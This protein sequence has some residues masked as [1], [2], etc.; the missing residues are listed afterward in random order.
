MPTRDLN[1]GVIFTG[2]IEASLQSAIDKLKGGMNELNKSFKES[3][4]VA[5]DTKSGFLSLNWVIKDII[6][7]M[8]KLLMVQA[9]WYGA[10]AVLFAAIEAPIKGIKS[11]IE[12]TNEIEKGRAEMLRWGATSGEVTEDMKRQV[13]LIVVMMRRATTE[14]PVTLQ[15]LSKAVQAFAGAGVEYPVLAGMVEGIAKLKTSFKEI[16]I[17]QWAVA[18]R[19]AFNVF[20]TAMKEGGTE[21]E[22]MLLIF[23]KILRAQAVGIARPEEFTKVLKFMGSITDLL[24]GNIDQML[25]MAVAISNVQGNIS[26]AARMARS[27]LLSMQTDKFLNFAKIVGIPIDKSKNLFSQLDVIIPELAKKIDA[28]NP[29]V[30]GWVNAL[31]KTMGKQE[32]DT[33]LK[34]IQQYKEYVRLTK[35][36]AESKGGLTAAAAVMAMPPSEQWK[37]FVNILK[38]VSRAITEYLGSDLR[39]ITGTFVDF[40]RGIL[41]A[42]DP[43]GI[44]ADKIDKLGPAGKFAYNI[45]TSIVNAFKNL[46]VI[47]QPV[48]ILFEAFG[49]IILKVIQFLVE[50]NK[51]LEFLITMLLTKGILS[52]GKWVIGLA[53]VVTAFEGIISIIGQTLGSFSG[54]GLSIAMIIA[55]IIG[56]LN[57]LLIVLTT[58]GMLISALSEKDT[59]PELMKF[60]LGLYTKSKE[61]LEKELKSLQES[62]KSFQQAQI[63]S[64]EYV[65]REAEKT[66]GLPVGG[67]LLI[68]KEIR[69]K[70]AETIIPYTAE[71]KFIKEKIKLTK[72]YYDLINKQVKE[73]K[74]GGKEEPPIM[75]K[76][77]V[78]TQMAARR[79]IFNA[80]IAERKSNLATESHLLE[81]QFK[82]NLIS[83]E[84]YYRRRQVLRDNDAKLF[85][86]EVDYEEQAIKDTYAQ[87]LGINIKGM[88]FETFKNK[89]NKM[90]E[91]LITPNKFGVTALSVQGDKDTETRKSNILRAREEIAK[92]SF[93]ITENTN[94]RIQMSDDDYFRWRALQDTRELENT[95]HVFAM[96]NELT[97]Q[98][99]DM[100]LWAIEEERKTNKFRYDNLYISTKE[101]YDKELELINQEEASKKAALA[102]DL[103]A[104]KADNAAK[105][106]LAGE[107]GNLIGKLRDQAALYERQNEEKITD[108]TRQALSKRLDLQKQ[109]LTDWEILYDEGIVP[110]VSE[111]IRRIIGEY[112][113][114]GSRIKSI[115]DDIAKGMATSFEDFFFDVFKIQLKSGADYFN[116]F[117]DVLLRAMSKFLGEQIVKSFLELLALYL[118]KTSSGG[119]ETWPSGASVYMEHSGGLISEA[120]QYR[121]LNNIPRFHSGIGPDE[122]LSILK[123]NEGVFTPGQMRA[124]GDRNLS[125][126]VNVENKTSSPANAKVG[127][128]KFDGKKY[129]VSVILEDIDKGGVLRHA[130]AGVR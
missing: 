75:G 121:W 128:T 5:D 42:V 115:V 52:L 47:L 102:R 31:S 26:S 77:Q 61:D 20:G 46:G 34:F 119:G 94:K 113:K 99:L 83:E 108:I 66:H 86:E 7:D 71:I 4:K 73:G 3:K 53:G 24:G 14:F 82:A 118:S 127:E 63:E 79:A 72:E 62:L 35:E 111:A 22:K 95:E 56:R 125:V 85:K 93:K 11:M 123:K 41:V 45:T 29:V 117:I 105:I 116:A 2:K 74:G 57:P 120:N 16:N 81:G 39:K 67:L 8:E 69:E 23:E 130:I 124:L 112:D 100:Q 104:F 103:E 65:R 1:L 43:L 101:Y 58:I 27:F 6:K 33:L 97:K 25:A 55:G 40:A 129:V 30:V 10:K 98:R 90:Y 12:Y 44:F 32:M 109:Y 51:I 126:E 19:G 76:D 9:R 84:E 18:V 122:R 70:E 13:D 96:Y 92:E 107:N 48:I 68:P 89:I 28:A 80:W 60:K 114:M 36:V 38:E 87:K 78:A 49:S 91:D 64:D 59:G 88:D 21:A 50:H 17:E 15:E 37:I 106:V 54:F 110:V